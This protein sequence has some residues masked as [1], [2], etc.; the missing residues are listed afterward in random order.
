MSQAQDNRQTFRDLH[1]TPFIIPNPWDL[2]SAKILA[3]LGFQALAT[4][5]S[6]FA[7]SLGRQDGGVSAKKPSPIHRR[8]SPQHP[9]RSAPISKTAL[10]IHRKRSPRPCGKPSPPVSPDARSKDFS[11]EELYEQGLAVERVQAAVETNRAN[12]APL[13]L[14]ARAENHIRGNPDLADTISRL[15]AYQEAGADVLYA[16]GLMTFDDIR[17][18]TSAVDRPV[19]VLIMPGGP[20]VPEIYEAGGTRVSVGS[21]IAAAAQAALVEAGRELLDSGTHNFWT[22]AVGSL[23]LVTNAME[24]RD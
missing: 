3:A 15:Q 17:S 10:A 7:N 11:G 19:N 8:S 16:P 9:C 22:K 2:G 20:S 14:T 24:P 13:V 18:V 23:G 6:G 5:S 4:T 12:E 21:A 1:K